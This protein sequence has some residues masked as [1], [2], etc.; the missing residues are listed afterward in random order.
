MSVADD[1][2]IRSFGSEECRAMTHISADVGWHQPEEE[3][4]DIIRRSGKFL[5]GAFHR[6]QLIG[7][8]AAYAYPDGGFAFINEVIVDSQFRRRGIAAALLR[9]L[10]PLTA[11]EYPVLRLYATDMG[12]PLYEKFG[13]EPYAALSFLQLQPGK[14]PNPDGV[15]M[16]LT[17]NEL[18][19]AAELDR[20]NFGADRSELIRSLLIAS[21]ENAWMQRKNGRMTGFIVR[22][23]MSWLLQTGS[24][25]DMTSLIR[26]ADKH[27]GKGSYPVLI[28][29]E[30]AEQLSGE[31]EVHFQLTAMQRGA[32]AP[33]RIS[34]GSMRPDIG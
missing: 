5:F 4:L 15:I 30:H 32:G 14:T 21:P 9:K 3:I 31:C 7:T 23:P 28:H 8:A 29:Q 12:R 13:F 34:F 2:E 1:F 27:S 26:W 10:I 22:G 18:A 6:K 25:E 16:P 19:E 11:A 33:P 24:P 17:Q 20:N